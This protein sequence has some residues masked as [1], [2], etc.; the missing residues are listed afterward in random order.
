MKVNRRFLKP[1]KCSVTKKTIY[2]TEKDAG[3]GMMR[4]WSHDTTADIFDL[5][6]Y[7]CSH[8]GGWHVGHK[9]YYEKAL[10]KNPIEVQP[11]A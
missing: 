5:H 11:N 9:S 7:G 4:I 1:K 2:H 6:I 10:A 3:R 8:C